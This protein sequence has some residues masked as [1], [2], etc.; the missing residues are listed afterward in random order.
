ML[1]AGGLGCGV[2]AT[3]TGGWC[4]RALCWRRF[5]LPPGCSLAERLGRSSADGG[6]SQS[7]LLARTGDGLGDHPV[8]PEQ[9][10]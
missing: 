5:Q 10:P 4:P 1:K 9:E 6:Q 2:G 7:F 3:L 8:L